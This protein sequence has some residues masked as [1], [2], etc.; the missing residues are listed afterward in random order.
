MITSEIQK[1]RYIYYRCTRKRGGCR[2]PFLREDA[3]VSQISEAIEKVAISGDLK[4]F[5]FD[6]IDSE[7]SVGLPPSAS[8]LALNNRISEIDRKLNMLLDSYINQVISEEEYKK[9]KS[10]LLN[11]KLELKEKLTSDE[12]KG[13]VWLEL[14]RTIVTSAGQASYI[15]RKGSLEEKREF[16]KKIGFNFRLADAK[17]RFEYRLPYIYFAQKWPKEKWGG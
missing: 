10:I 1:Q 4:K 6:K 13:K 14:A 2:Q 16:A 9:K 5:L 11:E 15:A 3:L 12:G 17:L 7:A 8:T